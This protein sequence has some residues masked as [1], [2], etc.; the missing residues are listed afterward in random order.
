M[1]INEEDTERL[2]RLTSPN[3]RQYKPGQYKPGIGPSHKNTRTNRKSTYVT[4][5]TP[6][7]MIRRC[8]TR[9]H[10]YIKSYTKKEGHKS[11]PT[12]WMCRWKYAR[13]LTVKTRRTVYECEV[14]RLPLCLQCFDDF[15]SVGNN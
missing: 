13:K 1:G 12:C 5:K 8:K 2:L 4:A 10:H 9:T 11:L 7:P 14:C 3:Y 6:L 15:H